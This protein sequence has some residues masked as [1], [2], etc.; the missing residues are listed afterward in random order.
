MKISRLPVLPLEVQVIYWFSHFRVTFHICMILHNATVE[1]YQGSRIH[2]ITE[3]QQWLELV[4]GDGHPLYM[5]Q[6][7]VHAKFLITVSNITL[8]Q[9]SPGFAAIKTRQ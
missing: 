2:T 6:L 1:C 7:A 8:W 3:T 9:L 4:S 5:V